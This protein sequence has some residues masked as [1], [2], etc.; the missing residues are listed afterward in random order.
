MGEDR[1]RPRRGRGAGRCLAHRW[2]G[3]ARD[4]DRL[5]PGRRRDHR[6]DVGGLDARR[7]ARRRGAPVV[8]GRA[9]GRG[10]VRVDHRRVRA[11]GRRGGSL[12]RRGLP[13]R[14]LAAPD[15][16]RVL[17]A[18]ASHADPAAALHAGERRQRLAAARELLHRAAARAGAPGRAERL[19]PPPRPLD[20]GLRLRHRRPGGVRPQRVAARR[21]R[22]RRRRLVRDPGLLPPGRDRRAPLRGR[23]HVLRVEPRPAASRGASTS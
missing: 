6:R 17:G 8:H 13:A 20:R 19:G 21:A 14:C 2:P 18:G 5:G 10:D 3:R 15:R 4:R 23:R 1:T 16:P 7:A 12:G 22:R 9:L 11:P